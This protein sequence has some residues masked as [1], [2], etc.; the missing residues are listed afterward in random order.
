MLRRLRGPLRLSGTL[1]LL[2]AVTVPLVFVCVT[3]TPLGADRGARAWA[4]PVA[5][6]PPS[7]PAPTQAE[8]SAPAT[9]QPVATTRLQPPTTTVGAAVTSIAK[10]SQAETSVTGTTAAP[11]TTSECGTVAPTEAAGR[12]ACPSTPPACRT[13]TTTATA[14]SVPCTTT[15]TTTSTTT[16]TTRPTTTTPDTTTPEPPPPPPSPDPQRPPVPARYRPPERAL[17]LDL[18]QPPPCVVLNGPMAKG[19]Y[20]VSSTFG[21]RGG[22]FHRG[23]DL[24]AKR[25]TP[26]FAALDG[27]VVAAGQA[28]GFGNWIVIDSTTSDGL[29][30]TVYGHMYDDGMHVATGDVV[31]AGQHIADVGSN[32]ASSGPHLHF[33]LW[34][35][36][37]LQNGRFVNPAPLLDQ[38]A[39]AADQSALKMAHSIADCAVRPGVGLAPGK[40]PAEFVPWLRKGAADCPGSGI[41]APLLA[42][43]LKAENNFRHGATAPVS[44]S[45]AMGPAQFLPGT[46]ETWKVDA[47]GDGRSDINSIADAVV[48]QAHFMCK[49]WRDSTAGIAGGQ[50]SGDAVDLALAAYNAGFGAVQAARG[51]PSGGEYTTQTQPYVRKIRAYEREFAAADFAAAA[52]QNAESGAKALRAVQQY[53]GTGYIWGGGNT[54][55]P[56]QG[57]FDSPGLATYVAYVATDGA[58]T[59]PRTVQQQWT[60]GQELP[61]DRAGPGQLVYTDFGPNGVPR[62]VGI[63]IGDGRMIHA[64]A[65]DGKVAEAPIPPGAKI[66]SMS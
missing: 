66:R 29:V 32:G 51:M 8:R 31:K 48:A 15:T 57:G 59:L 13:T 37:R 1:T 54:K 52:G 14:T 11:T 7:T 60:K 34:Q 61:A 2:I 27:K 16:T 35:G 26:I 44:S 19:S 30:S 3:Q 25:G 43:Q 63:A 17:P 39:P 10:S 5:S 45:G 36:G 33:E 50:L 53:L 20:T 9:T 4:Q 18:S 6:Q 55:G 12:A 24:A 38:A 64:S 21:N 56:T 49:N 46:W 40:V 47:D 58:V 62:H 41:T 28:T 23:M 42:G 22:E 65:E